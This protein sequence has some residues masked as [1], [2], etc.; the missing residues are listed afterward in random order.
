[1][2]RDKNGV[3]TYEEDPERYKKARKR[4]QNRESAI[5]SRIKKREEVEE[6]EDV[7][8]KLQEEKAAIESENQALKR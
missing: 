1:M 3:F 2:I 6:L 8:R 5:R 7:V 4:L